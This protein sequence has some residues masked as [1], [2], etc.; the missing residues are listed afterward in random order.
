MTLMLPFRHTS[1]LGDIH[2]AISLLSDLHSSV[3]ANDHSTSTLASTSAVFLMKFIVT[4]SEIYREQALMQHD[5]IIGAHWAD[6]FV[7]RR[8][9]CKM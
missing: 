6:K 9:Y 1:Q 7:P 8:G 3:Q 2:K 4:A 5:L